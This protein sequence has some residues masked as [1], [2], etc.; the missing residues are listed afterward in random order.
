MQFQ[1]AED[2]L[3]IWVSGVCAGQIDN[4]VELY[5]DNAIL[6]PTFSPHTVCASEGI[7]HYFEQL[8]TRE[9]LQ[10]RLYEKSVKKQFLGGSAWVLS[11][12]YAFEFEV[13]Q[14]LL[15]FPSRFTF[16]LN[17]EHEKPILHHHSSQVPRN[18]S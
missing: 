5:H 9:N 1:N 12:M 16:G 15:T 7:R 10:V 2:V 6:I 14:L 11:G 4:I 13:D 8:S 3:T 17:L 18:L